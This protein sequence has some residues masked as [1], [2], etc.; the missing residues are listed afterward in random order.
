MTVRSLPIDEASVNLPSGAVKDEESFC[1]PRICA[2]LAAVNLAA[3]AQGSHAAL[4]RG[5]ATL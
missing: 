2:G 3:L 4:F 1:S 5:T